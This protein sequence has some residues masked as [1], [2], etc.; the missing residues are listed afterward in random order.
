MGVR[1]FD[2]SLGRFISADTIVPSPYNPLAHDRYSYSYNNPIKFVDPT[3]HEPQFPMIDGICGAVGSC[4][5]PVIDDASVS[6]DDSLGGN[7]DDKAKDDDGNYQNSDNNEQ[8]TYHQYEY[9]MF[10]CALLAGTTAMVMELGTV[11]T[12]GGV[13]LIVLGPDPFSKGVGITMEI[14]AAGTYSFGVLVMV[15]KTI[16]CIQANQ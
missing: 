10:S 3:G 16:D 1:W 5:Q 13:V 14:I 11:V 8:E 2:P 12:F 7:A 4:N 9:G 6:F 15:P